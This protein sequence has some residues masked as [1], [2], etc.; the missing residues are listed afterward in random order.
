MRHALFLALFLA[1]PAAAQSAPQGEPAE[2]TI[3]VT[4]VRVQDYRDALARCLARNCPPNEDADA[5]LA[6][7]EALFLDGEYREGRDTVQASLRRNARQA[8]NFPEPVSDLYRAHGRLSRHLGFDEDGRRSTYGI[9]RAL[10]EGIAQEDHRHFTARM[11]I[12]DLLMRSANFVSAR[13]ELRQLVEVARRAGRDDVATIAELRMLLIDEVITPRGEARGRLIQMARLTGPNDR[14]R[15]TGAKILLARIYRDEGNHRRAD[16]LI[17]EAGQAARSGPARRLLHAP[18]YRLQVQNLQQLI[19]GGIP[20]N[21]EDKWI[22]VGFWVMP[23]GRV[24]GLEILRQSTR[25]D[26]ADPL[27]RSIRGRRY[28]DGA[29]PTYR[30]ERYTYTAAYARATRTR[31]AVRSETARIEYLD[32]TTDEPPNALPPAR[33]GERQ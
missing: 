14:M 29:E 26:W 31:L 2:Q 15:S 28:S 27:I 33:P 4:G 17:A 19:P 25:P 23:D 12:I 20:D 30:M 1:A 10:R 16:A 21:F 6:L 32:L 22:D 7:A 13:R 18:Q 24:A 5:T 8:R 11:E 9:L 3:L